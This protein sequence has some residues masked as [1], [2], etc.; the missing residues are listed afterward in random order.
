M[1][2]FYAKTHVFIRWR[3]HGRLQSSTDFQIMEYEEKQ[4]YLHMK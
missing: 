4:E 3:F 2:N 1:I